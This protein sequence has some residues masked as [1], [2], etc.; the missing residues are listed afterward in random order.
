MTKEYKLQFKVFGK[1]LWVCIFALLYGLGGIEFKFIRRFIAPV[2][3]GGGMYLFSK[4]WRTLLQVPLLMGSLSLGYG[5]EL[6]WIKVAKR[7]IY[8]FI[9][10]LTNITHRS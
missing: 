4:D 2:W 6:F 1:L 8:G 7:A 3:L 9:N 5:A 10:G